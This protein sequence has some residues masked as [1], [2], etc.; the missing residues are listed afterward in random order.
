MTLEIN[1]A[2]IGTLNFR[3]TFMAS[4]AFFANSTKD[5]HIASTSV[6]VTVPAVAAATVAGT[7]ALA[8][9]LS[10]PFLPFVPFAS[11]FLPPLVS[12]D[13]CFLCL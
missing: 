9:I 13:L 4:N 10:L 7:A 8:T 11:P 12:L 3:N 6:I 5:F 2:K 1:K